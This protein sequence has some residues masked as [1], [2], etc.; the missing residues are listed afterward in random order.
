MH[1]DLRLFTLLDDHAPDLRE[2]RTLSEELGCF[3]DVGRGTRRL[4]DDVHA[5]MRLR[6]LLVPSD[7]AY[8]AGHAGE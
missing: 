7:E 5:V 2:A 1:T 8:D 6:A 4:R 3:D